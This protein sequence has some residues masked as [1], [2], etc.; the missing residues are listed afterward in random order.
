MRHLSSHTAHGS[1]ALRITADEAPFRGMPAHRYDVEGFDTANN[2]AV[3]SGGFVPRFRQ[4]SIIFAT[5]ESAAN[6]IGPDGV[7]M[8]ALLAILGDHLQGL[9]SGPTASQGKQLAL[10]YIE[11]A[12][13]ILAQEA[14][15]QPAFGAGFGGAFMAPTFGRTG[16]TGSL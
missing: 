10:E 7:T 12:R 14:G 5:E 9:Q 16:T 3:R 4:L 2:R 11:A 1:S 15:T 8:E 6:D 13:D